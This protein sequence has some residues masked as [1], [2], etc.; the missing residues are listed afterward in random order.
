MRFIPYTKTSADGDKDFGEIAETNIPSCLAE[1]RQVAIRYQKYTNA[2]HVIYGRKV[3]S[4]DGTL[5]EMKF[6]MLAL[7]DKDFNERVNRCPG[8]V[9]YCVH[10]QN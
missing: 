8:D 4:I 9:F 5:S 1:L 2:D 3:Y 6:Y 10:K 7:C